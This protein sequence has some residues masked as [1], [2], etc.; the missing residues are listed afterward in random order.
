[1]FCCLSLYLHIVSIFVFFKGSI[2]NAVNFFNLPVCI[3]IISIHEVYEWSCFYIDMESCNIYNWSEI[4]F[5]KLSIL[6]LSMPWHLAVIFL[7]SCFAS[8]A[9]SESRQQQQNSILFIWIFF[10]WEK[11]WE[12]SFK[13]MEISLASN[14]CLQVS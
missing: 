1:M 14:F 6:S 2:P 12:K 4:L 8:I 5:G 11:I 7:T 10:D 9:F 13:I 3:I